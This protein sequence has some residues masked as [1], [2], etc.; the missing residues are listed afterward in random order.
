MAKGSSD[1]KGVGFDEWY[2]QC[3]DMEEGP[4][5]VSAPVRMVPADEEQERLDRVQRHEQALCDA[6]SSVDRVLQSSTSELGKAVNERRIGIRSGMEL[7]LEHEKV[8]EEEREEMEKRLAQRERE[9]VEKAE[10]AER[11]MNVLRQQLIAQKEELNAVNAE[12]ERTAASVV[13]S[14]APPPGAGAGAPA[15]RPVLQRTDSSEAELRDL[16]ERTAAQDEELRMCA[17]IGQSLLRG[18]EDAELEAS[19]AA[20]RQAAMGGKLSLL[21]AEVTALERSNRELA[22]S[23]EE[24]ENAALSVQQRAERE[25]A[26]VRAD[27]ERKLAQAREL[28]ESEQRAREEAERAKQA[29]AEE[30]AAALSA[31]RAKLEQELEHVKSQAERERLLREQAE[32][33]RLAREVAEGSEIRKRHE[34]QLERERDASF[35]LA[36]QAKAAE[37]EVALQQAV[38]SLNA[39]HA[40]E[41]AAVAAAAAVA[42]QEAAAPRMCTREKLEASR[43]KAKAQAAAAGMIAVREQEAVQAQAQAQAQVEAEEAEE[44]AEESEENADARRVCA[45]AE[46]AVKGAAQA[47][48]RGEAEEPIATL[49]PAPTPTRAQ[50]S[51]SPTSAGALQLQ[52][53]LVGILRQHHA[54]LAQGHPEA[55]PGPMTLNDLGAAV[56]AATGSSWNAK[57]AP[58]HGRLDLYV[59]Q[60]PDHFVLLKG[61]RVALAGAEYPRQQPTE[62]QRRAK[63]QEQKEEGAPAM[64]MNELARRRAHSR[65]ASGGA[66]TQPNRLNFGSA[67]TA[68]LSPSPRPPPQQQLRPPPPRPQ[69]AMASAVGLGAAAVHAQQLQAERVR[70]R[71]EHVRQQAE[72]AKPRAMAL[73]G[74]GSEWAC[75][76]CTLLNPPLAPVCAACNSSRAIAHAQPAPPPAAAVTAAALPADGGGGGGH[77]RTDWIMSDGESDEDGGGGGGGGGGGAGSD[78]EGAEVVR[79]GSA[80]P[81]GQLLSLAAVA[82]GGSA[83]A[84]GDLSQLGAV[85]VS[86]NSFYCTLWVAKASGLLQKRRVPRLVLLTVGASSAAAAGSSSSSPSTAPAASLS[87]SVYPSASVLGMGVGAADAAE[88]DEAAPGNRERSGA[89]SSG[90]GVGVSCRCFESFDAFSHNQPP[91]EQFQLG[92]GMRMGLIKRKAYSSAQRAVVSGVQF[93]CKL[94][95]VGPGGVVGLLKFGCANMEAMQHFVQAAEAGIALAPAACTSTSPCKARAFEASVRCD[96]APSGWGK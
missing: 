30:Q 69:H 54:K 77:E 52:R 25:L 11:E 9:L 81:F 27:M 82:G 8:L 6:I 58:Q 94:A 88:A 29:E 80:L 74:T 96:Q 23:G 19:A 39:Q 62:G 76:T 50:Q 16:R 41:R 57:F 21:R 10:A 67:D 4:L 90:L 70:Q 64:S 35:E 92:A 63:T 47:V 32:A 13:A 31:T 36:T 72:R 46:Q 51:Q 56:K 1:G 42:V 17:E 12:R 15:S 33:E 87:S 66:H 95:S 3:F 71:A 43:G 55:G 45:K 59:K 40:A 65:S 61:N 38:D 5:A 24:A 22:Q 79:K 78:E 44:E 48:A 20:E 60:H 28:A 26:Q 53:G 89:A 34:Q 37:H 49:A 68:V 2:K 86:R 85:F 83:A 7:E 75:S 18:K 91:K 14:S 93:T 84:I 73:E